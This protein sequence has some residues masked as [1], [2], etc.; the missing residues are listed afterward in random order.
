MEICSHSFE[1]YLHKIGIAE[2]NCWTSGMTRL[3]YSA[4]AFTFLPMVN[5]SLNF[6]IVLPVLFIYLFIYLFR[7]KFLLC[8][9]GWLRTHLCRQS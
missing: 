7:D 3:F 2:S 9:P 5:E 6:S 4:A 1:E 8:N